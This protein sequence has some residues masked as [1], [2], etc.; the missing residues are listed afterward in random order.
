MAK[1]FRKINLA[2]FKSV[3]L[4]NCKQDREFQKTLCAAYFGDNF[5]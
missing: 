3:K 5:A 4:A 1:K 2:S